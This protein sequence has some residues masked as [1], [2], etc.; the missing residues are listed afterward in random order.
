LIHGFLGRRGG[1]STGRYAGLNLSFRVGDDPQAV[2]DN[3]CDMKRA[4]GVHDLRIVTMR[5]LHGDR[6][7][8]VK[9]GSLKEAGEADGMVTEE[10]GLFLGVLTADCVPILFSVSGRPLVAAVHAG[11]RGTLAGIAAKMVRHLQERYG[12][13]AG[14]VE[15][16]LGPSIGPCCYEIG[17][18]VSVPLLEKWGSMAQKSLA[19][20]S[21]KAFLDLRKLNR[22]ILASA[23]VPA[24]KIR[25]I[26]PCTSCA[27]DDFF[28]YRR[29][30]GETGRQISF[31]GWL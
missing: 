23:G 21:G 1:K 7:L 14:L 26:G 12:V 18:D 28:S 13:G 9:D 20:A 4:V 24:E 11:W 30:K 19:E 5:Q 27:P 31:I 22:L 16:A 8:D 3:I 10:R 6:I 29:E 15:T 17:A 25:E 2:K